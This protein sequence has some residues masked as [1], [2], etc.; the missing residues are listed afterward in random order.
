MVSLEVV[1]LIGSFLILLSIAI[2]KFT[3]NLGVPALLLFL[4]IGML[5]GSE[6]PG[7]IYFDDASSAQSIGIIALIFILF[8]GGLD[9]NW[10]EVKPIVWQAMSLATVGVFLTALTVGIF[11]VFILD[12]SVLEGLLLGAVISS[13]DAAAVFSILRSRK[14]SLKGMLKPLLELESGSN[15]P[16]AVFLTVGIVQLILTPDSKWTYLPLLFLFQMGVGSIMGLGFGKVVVL[17]LNRMKF[18]YEG[19]YPVFSLAFAVFI[20]AITTAIGGSGFLA[21][22]LAGILIGNSEVVHKKNLFRFFDGLAWLSQIGMF[23][24]LGLLVFPS[25]LLPVIGIGFMVSTFLVFI[26][27]PV[28]VY[29]SL[30][31]SNHAWRE[32]A[33]VSWVG[34]RGAVPIILATFPLLANVSNAKLIFNLVFFIVLTSTL[35]QGWSIPIVAKFLKVNIPVKQKRW[36]PIEFESRI[37]IDTDLIELIVPYTSAA[38]GKSLVELGLPNDSLVVLIVR[39]D[40][41]VVPSGGTVLEAGDTLLVLVNKNNLSQVRVILAEQLGD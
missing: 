11:A 1:L 36:Y 21:V 27:R 24:T 41:Y 28:S 25:H 38:V 7:G 13:T 9:T 31:L 6:G 33:V 15:D 40:N 16:M 34:L 18:S 30:A 19:F 20:Y 2:A 12:F 35:L 4:A 3:D 32:K 23:L 26:A 8:A 17:L 14:I 5:V 22:Y 10:R 37:G 29:I 39:N